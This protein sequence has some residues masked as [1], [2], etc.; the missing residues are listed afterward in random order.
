[1]FRQKFANSNLVFDGTDHLGLAGL[2]LSWPRHGST[3]L[4]YRI[5]R[6]ATADT[7]VFALSGDMN[8][9]HATRLR[10]LLATEATHRVT[11]DLNDI[12][13]VDRAAVR[14]LVDAVAGGI[15][16]INCPDYVRSWIAA[17]R[18]SEQLRI[19]EPDDSEAEP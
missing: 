9:E 8:S 4:T 5:R 3:A 15:R 13:L 2:L 1:M 10:E 14:F 17:E 19:P 12:T 11:L 6:V 18:D 16:L 7:V